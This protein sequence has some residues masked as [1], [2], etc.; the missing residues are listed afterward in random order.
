MGPSTSSGLATTFRTRARSR[1]GIAIRARKQWKRSGSSRRR[2]SEDPR[3]ATAQAGER[4]RLPARDLRPTL[5]LID[6]RLV[7]RE[8][9]VLDLARA[10]IRRDDDAGARRRHVHDLEPRRD[11]ASG[12][13]PLPAAEHGWEGPQVELVDKVIP[14]ERLDEV[15][16]PVHLDLW[17]GLL[18]QLGH[19]HRHVALDE[20]GV[21]PLDVL[22]RP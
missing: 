6:A 21:V 19:V 16:A 13:E 8:R 5:E 1:T 10:L 4:V 14:Q 22:E 18:L 12:E 17:S 11:R 20:C 9:P 15:A 3:S 2:R 7:Q